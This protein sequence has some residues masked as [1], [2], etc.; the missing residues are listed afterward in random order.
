MRETPIHPTEVEL[1][2]VETPRLI[3][4]KFRE[5]D[6]TA[7]QSIFGD[8]EVMQHGPGLQTAEWIGAWLR[9]CLVGYARRGYGPWAVV[10]KG[11][12]LVVG[13]CGYSDFPDI[14][15]RPEVELGYRLTRAT[16]GQGYATEA[17]SAVRDYAWGTLALRRLVAL[18][19]PQNTASIRVAEKIGMRYE[20]DVM[21]AGYT[22]P[23]RLY[24]VEKPAD[25]L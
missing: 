3:L 15:G 11:S 17:A 25:S 21:L 20:R 19:D 6:Q 4:R 16:W 2:I 13:Y 9:D 8:A 12:G 23:D 24:S 10:E 5:I 22:Y 18:I 1:D 14:A 7:L